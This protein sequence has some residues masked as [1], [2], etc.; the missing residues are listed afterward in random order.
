MDRKKY[1]NEE[2]LKYWKNVTDDANQDGIVTSVKKDHSRDFK[3]PGEE[4][5]IRFFETLDI[6]EEE[7]LLDYGCGF[8]RFYPYFSERSD[9]YGIDISKAMIEE[10]QKNYPEAVDRF[11]VA[12]GEHLPFA[13]CFFDKIICCGVFDACY[14]ESALAEMTRVCKDGGEVL[15]TG[16]NI[17][18]L[19][20]DEQALIA[21]EAARKKGHPNYFTDVKKM[22][23][24]L[25]RAGK[26]VENRFYL[27]RGDFGQDRYVN[28]I[29]EK[30][31][32]W[33]IVFRKSNTAP[34]P[35]MEL[36]S[37][38]YSVTWKRKN[39]SIS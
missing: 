28:T 12:E 19:D 36:F 2:Y 16:E 32:E 30:F 29:P 15:I 31:Y 24:W 8:G 5:I 14:Q 23:D 26:I 4:V 17:N 21:E 35:D 6:K 11:L 34:P 9:Y 39:P 38:P 13:E 7:K 27:Y 10:C 22:L 20:D 37:S 25:Q 18:Y 3:A 1:W 33:A